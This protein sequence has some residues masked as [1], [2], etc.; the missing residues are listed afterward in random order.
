MSD[1]LP[2]RT[3][4]VVGDFKT[5]R[6]FGHNLIYKMEEDTIQLETTQQRGNLKFVETYTVAEF[7]EKNGYAK[8]GVAPTS[9]DRLA[10][11]DPTK[12]G[13]AQLIG[14]VANSLDRSKEMVVSLCEKEDGSTMHMLHNASTLE[15]L[16]P[17]F[18]L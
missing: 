14:S 17:V 12:E 1:D 18:E 16:K 2:Y 7:K 4:R 11:I 8:I 10:M 15:K 9:R 13:I 6:S 5:A 3:P